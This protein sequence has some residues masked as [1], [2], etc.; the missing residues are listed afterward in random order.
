MVTE[1]KTSYLI[2]YLKIYFWQILSILSSFLSMLIVTP[3]LSANKEILGIY[4]IC[5]S[6]SIFLSYADLG[7]LSAGQ[8]YAA[9]E[10]AKNNRKEE[11]KIIGFT[12]F[13]LTIFILI[14]SSVFLILSIFPNL[15]IPNTDKLQFDIARKLL[16]IL[17]IFSPLTIFSRIFQVIFGIRI[18][19]FI[20]QR[21]QIVSNLVKIISAFYFFGNNCYRIVEYYLFGNLITLV[22]VV[23]TFLSI[24]KKYRYPM[25][26]LFSNFRFNLILFKKTYKLAI[27]N[28]LLTISWIVYYECDSIVISKLW[29]PSHV[30]VYAIGLTLLNMIRSLLGTFFGPFN[31]RFNHYIGLKDNDSLIK[32]YTQVIINTFPIVVYTVVVIEIFAESLVLS[33][34]GVNYETS[35]PIAKMLILCNVMAF[36]A[37]PSSLIIIAKERV[38]DILIISFILPLLY[39]LIIILCFSKVG[40]VSFSFAKLIIFM[41]NALFYF[42]IVIKLL[43]I[44]IL[45]LLYELIKYNTLPLL[46]MIPLLFYLQKYLSYSK[47][48][49]GLLRTIFIGA[50]IGLFFMVCSYLLNKKIRSPIFQKLRN[51]KWK[52]K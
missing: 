18:E 41:I 24:Y 52:M 7:F 38:R 1:V 23:I 28:I 35:I 45:N 44:E 8:K 6:I 47:N 20:Y 30:A 32:S 37:Y 17:F 31:S 5:T 51:I 33:W 21:I 46:C 9:E 15:L 27:S 4:S 11:I 50:G 14:C 40:L 48:S 16:L 13:I 26:E 36:I 10:Y 39:W 49:I 3:S 34:V 2:N 19:E 22:S 29:G 12:G 43:K 25:L 42:I